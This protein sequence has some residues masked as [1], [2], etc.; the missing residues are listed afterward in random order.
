MGKELSPEQMETNTRGNGR[1]GKGMGMEHTLYLMEE[2]QWVNLEKETIGTQ[3]NATN[4]E[5]SMGSML[6]ENGKKL[7]P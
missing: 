1:M 4:T 5:T 6:M 7:T 3:K 2:K